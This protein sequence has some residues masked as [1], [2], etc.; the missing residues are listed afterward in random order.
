[1]SRVRGWSDS[2]GNLRGS[3]LICTMGSVWY[4]KNEQGFYDYSFTIAQVDNNRRIRIVISQGELE[5]LIMAYNASQ[6]EIKS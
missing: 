1:M 5:S 6:K 4:T 3:V 2:K